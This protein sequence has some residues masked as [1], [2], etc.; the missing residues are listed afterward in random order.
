MFDV[1]WTN[2]IVTSDALYRSKLG[3]A[4]H[5]G[6]PHS[7]NRFIDSLSDILVMDT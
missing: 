3:G 4:C 2:I 1:R 5:I 6:D 7:H